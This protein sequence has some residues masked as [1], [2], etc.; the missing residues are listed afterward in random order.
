MDSELFKNRSVGSCLNDA[1]D[2]FRSNFKTLFRRLWLPAVV[3]SLLLAVAMMFSIQNPDGSDNM[4]LNLCMFANYLLVIA[5]YVWFYTIIISLLNGRSVKANLPRITRLTFLIIGVVIVIGIVLA[6][7]AILNYAGVK[8]PNQL[9]GANIQLILGLLACMLVFF[10]ALLPLNFSVMKYCMEEDKKVF[11]IFQKPYVMGLRHWGYI[12]LTALLT[13]IIN[14]VISIV[15]LLPFY[16]IVLC[17]MINRNGM[18]FGDPSGLTGGFLFL[19]FITAA[20]CTFVGLFVRPW[21]VFS[22]YYAYGSIEEKE[23]GRKKS[24]ELTVSEE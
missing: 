10:V 8:N 19:A 16:V 18:A 20:V 3:L 23:K 13:G 6:G 21:I 7:G 5:A 24:K 1:F 15:V 17:N 14:M 9:Q 11:S 2:L 12:F 4:M 22:Y